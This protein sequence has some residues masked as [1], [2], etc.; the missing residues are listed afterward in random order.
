MKRLVCG[1]FV[2]IVILFLSPAKICQAEDAESLLDEY[3]YKNID[4]QIESNADY[5]ISFKELVQ[6]M[7]NSNDGKISFQKYLNKIS[8]MLKANKKAV[9]EIF[10]IGILSAILRTYTSGIGN[11]QVS[12]TAQ[13]ILSVTLVTILAAV[14]A[15]AVKTATD[16]LEGMIRFYQSIC[17]VFFPAVMVAGGSVAAGAYYQIVVMMIGVVN[18]VFKNILIQVNNIYLLLGIADSVTEEEHYSKACE[19]AQGAIKYISKTVLVIFLGLNGLKGMVAPFLDS[20]KKSILTRT[21]S[22]IP[23]VGNTAITVSK[24]MLGAGTIVK[25]SIGAAA[26]LVIV[27]ISALPLMK[28][29]VLAVLYKTLAAVLEP[30]AG[31]GIVNGVNICSRAVGNLIQ[32]LIVTIALLIMTIGIIC[33]TT[34]VGY[35]V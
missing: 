18:M 1:L 9:M 13:M 35:M 15:G 5:H 26:M 12:D 4:A 19:L 32:I 17:P 14:F 28:L 22:L 29:V 6:D 21:L 11:K 3:D 20:E 8:N 24:T 27:I 10:L 7:M 33:M 2:I 16:V 31:K 25:N 34:N 23:G 30:I